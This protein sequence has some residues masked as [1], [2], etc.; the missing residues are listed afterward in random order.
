[1]VADDEEEEEVINVGEWC[2]LMDEHLARF[3]GFIGKL[4]EELS[5]ASDKEEVEA[6]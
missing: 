2:E 5:N 6:R 3:D 1:M 4:K